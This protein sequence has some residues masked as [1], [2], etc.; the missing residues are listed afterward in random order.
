MPRPDMWVGSGFQLKLEFCPQDPAGLGQIPDTATTERDHECMRSTEPRCERCD[1]PV[2]QCE[3][4]RAPKRQAQPEPDLILISPREMAH[5]PGCPHKGDDPD[6]SNWA[7]IR[8]IPRAWE[9]IGN[10]EALDATG[11]ANKNLQAK[12]RCKDCETLIHQ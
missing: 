11:G 7:E 6:Y 10:G 12:I 2:G 3:H 4:T 5:I 1:L 8:N 9:R